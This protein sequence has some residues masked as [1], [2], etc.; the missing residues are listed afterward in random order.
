MTRRR[1]AGFQVGLGIVGLGLL[2]LPVVAVALSGTASADALWT[3]AAP[4]GARSVH[5]DL[6]RHR[7]E[8]L[9]AVLQQGHQAEDRPAASPV[10]RT[11]RFLSCRRPRDHGLRLRHLRLS[12]TPCLGGPRG[13]G[14][15]GG[16]DN[17]RV[18]AKAPASLLALDPPAQLSAVRG[19][20]GTRLHTRLRP[21]LPVVAEDL[22]R[23]ICLRG[24]CGA[25]VQDRER[26]PQR[27][28]LA[29]AEWKRTG[30]PRFAAPGCHRLEWPTPGGRW[31]ILHR[32]S[33]V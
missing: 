28:K 13:P 24:R 33:R 31:G 10:R 23:G 19:D 25:G 21:G 15:L 27:P 17:D 14:P 30:R 6:R 26:P 4:G 16:D 5:P 7:P 22:V 18:R 2:A 1:R 32:R 12:T 8:R 11:G 29:G 20:P 3:V 9:S